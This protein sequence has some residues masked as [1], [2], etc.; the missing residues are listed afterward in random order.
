[1]VLSKMLKKQILVF[2]PFKDGS[3]YRLFNRDFSQDTETGNITK[4]LEKAVGQHII[5]YNTGSE[6]KTAKEL[7]HSVKE[8]FNL[9]LTEK[10]YAD[11]KQSIE[12]NKKMYYD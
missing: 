4:L 6:D 1:M 2:K 12:M 8:H 3:I 7:P 11:F 5:L 9:L 10:Q